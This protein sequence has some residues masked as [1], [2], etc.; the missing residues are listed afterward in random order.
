[1]MYVVVEV[2]GCFDY[3]KLERYADKFSTRKF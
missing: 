1:M 3:G 2:G